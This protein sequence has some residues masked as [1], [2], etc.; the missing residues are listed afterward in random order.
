M[1]DIDAIIEETFAAPAAE[2]EA[3]ASTEAEAQTAPEPETE[4][5][6]TPAASTEAA[7]V[8]DEPSPSVESPPPAINWDT[9]ENPYRTQ[10][11]QEAEQ[12][13]QAEGRIAA[14]TQWLAQLQ[15]QQRQEQIRAQLQGLAELD[16]DQLPGTVQNLLND[17]VQ[18]SVQQAQREAAERERLEK[19]ITVEHIGGR[20]GLS[21]Q[22]K[23]TLF[24]FN[25]WQAMEQ[26]ATSIKAGRDARDAEL[27]SLRDKIAALELQT[28]AKARLDSNADLVGSTVGEGAS[29]GRSLEDIADFDEFF[30]ELT[31]DW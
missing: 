17:V 12:R 15:E 20:F 29:G 4:S 19:Y 13:R 22:E 31:K 9:D 11:A 18:P 14:A 1:D 7:A 16:P 8:A 10:A 3:E 5:S 23:Q 2:P 6:P 27:Q 28:Q 24:S 21:E 26:H 25:T 30:G